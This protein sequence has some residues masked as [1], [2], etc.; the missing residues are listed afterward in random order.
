MERKKGTV[1]AAAA[2]MLVLTGCGENKIP[3]LTDEQVV[4]LGEFTAVTLM[5]YDAN[6]RSRLV[7]YTT[8]LESTPAPESS[9]PTEPSKEPQGMDPVDDTPVIGA[10]STDTTADMEEILMLPE[11]M[12][13]S[14]EGYAVCGIYPEGES[15]FVITAAAGKKLLLLRFDILNVSD[16]EQ[17]VDLLAADCTFR[18][19]VNGSYTRNALLTG[20]PDD[21]ATFAGTI[22]AGGKASAVL[23]VEVDEETAGNIS[24]IVL[25]MKNDSKTC[26]IQVL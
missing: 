14:Y 23:L 3:N 6:N 12:S 19:T 22:P 9:A 8:M 24:S 2:L 7:D 10:D 26:T 5:R 13:V 21:L 16:T 1:L 17:A 20:L 18:I 15:D 4:Q 11:Q 25:K